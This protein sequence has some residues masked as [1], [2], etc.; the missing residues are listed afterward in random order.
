MY[1]DRTLQKMDPLSRIM[2][3]NFPEFAKVDG[4]VKHSFLALRIFKWFVLSLSDVMVSHKRVHASNGPLHLTESKINQMNKMR[5]TNTRYVTQMKSAKGL[6]VTKRHRD[7]RI[8]LQFY[9]F[10][11][12]VTMLKNLLSYQSLII[13]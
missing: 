4:R 10:W 9:N 13:W 2:F 6:S 8:C 12:I 7:Q 11:D 5:A 3:T 1:V